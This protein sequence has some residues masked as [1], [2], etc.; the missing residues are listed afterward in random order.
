[1]RTTDA[2]REP[3]PPRSGVSRSEADA[4]GEPSPTGENLTKDPKSKAVT[5]R[6]PLALCSQPELVERAKSGDK[7]ALDKILEECKPAILAAV[8]NH[9]AW[10]RHLGLYCWWDLYQ[11][12]QL[13][14]F[15][16][17]DN[18]VAERASGLIKSYAEY[19]IKRDVRYAAVRLTRP[20]SIST[21]LI[22]EMSLQAKKEDSVL[23]AG[24][25]RI[26]E[27]CECAAGAGSEMH[28][29]EGL[30]QDR[31][32]A[33]G[34][35]HAPDNDVPVADDG[36]R[37]CRP[38][39][40]GRTRLGER[41]GGR[42]KEARV[43]GALNRPRPYSLEASLNTSLESDRGHRALHELIADTAEPVPGEETGWQPGS[44][45]AELVPAHVVHAAVAQLPES[46]RI[47]I[48][49]RYGL[50]T[51]PAVSLEELARRIGVSRSACKEMLA[52]AR[53]TLSVEIPMRWFDQRVNQ[54]CA[55]FDDYELA[56]TG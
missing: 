43:Q 23:L 8:N 16:A 17:L 55:D 14:V 29:V 15:N 42:S 52:R 1:M 38:A 49:G 36:C 41:H 28:T 22:E 32:P 37:A 5:A 44:G 21:S 9:S 53:A 40:Q 45:M 35:S 25:W 27:P 13:A 51:E 30:N 20:E 48:V 18:Y 26:A 47:A 50:G 6:K 7:R 11:D 54:P 2:T 3:G 10:L 39:E 24:R 4:G 56:Q 31:C 33:P 19:Y 34:G 12:G 46:A